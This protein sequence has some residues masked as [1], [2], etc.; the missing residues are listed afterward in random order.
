M[1]FLVVLALAVVL[2][3]ALAATHGTTSTTTSP[4]G[5]LTTTTPK[6]PGLATASSFRQCLRSAGVFFSATGGIAADPARTKY[7]VPWDG[8]SPGFSGA[9]YIGTAVFKEG[10]FAD[11]WMI[12]SIKR[13]RDLEDSFADPSLNDPV[14]RD[15]FFQ[16]VR[17]ILFATSTVDPPKLDDRSGSEFDRCLRA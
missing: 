2:V 6:P 11:I 10:G 4:A 1:K 3:G 17:N 15:A 13:A 9:T 5:A 16:H 12:D 8:G 14:A 7:P